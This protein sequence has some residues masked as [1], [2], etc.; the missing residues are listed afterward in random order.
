M[1]DPVTGFD[2]AKYLSKKSFRNDF[3]IEESIHSTSESI[4]QSQ[5]LDFSDEMRNCYATLSA[6]SKPNELTNQ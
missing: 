1:M 6:V 2:K 4:G 3:V 5:L